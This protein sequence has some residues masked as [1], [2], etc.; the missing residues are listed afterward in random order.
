MNPCDGLLFW[1]ETKHLCHRPHC[2]S[3]P[4]CMCTR[5]QSAKLTVA[6]WLQS[7]SVPST[8]IGELGS[9]DCPKA[10]RLSHDSRLDSVNYIFYL[11]SVVLAH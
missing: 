2:R 11:I 4:A 3:S 10:D 5:L 9:K 7:C 1:S 8:C 6:T